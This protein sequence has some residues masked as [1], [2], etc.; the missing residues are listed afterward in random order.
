MLIK[1]IDVWPDDDGDDEETVGQEYGQGQGQGS[2]V[3][4][5][6]TVS[7]D[8]KFYLRVE[9]SEVSAEYLY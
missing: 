9:D 8:R 6:G 5:E 2:V 7:K 4:P 3:F 1:C